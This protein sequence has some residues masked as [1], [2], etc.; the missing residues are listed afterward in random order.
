MPR[1]LVRR[2]RLQL[3]QTAA[4]RPMLLRLQ[5]LRL[6][7]RPLL[8]VAL[9]LK[10]PRLLH[11]L[12]LRTAVHLLKLLT[13]LLPRPPILVLLRRPSSRPQARLLLMP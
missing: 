10:R 2:L 5:V 9:L 6:V 4:L 13:R 12:P 11:K 7:L 3:P 1:R 8:L